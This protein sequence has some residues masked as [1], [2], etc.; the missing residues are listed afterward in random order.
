MKIGS[1]YI[2]GGVSGSA[3]KSLEQAYEA[4]KETGFKA[5]FDAA[6]TSGDDEQLKEAAREFEAYFLGIML[7]QMRRTVIDGG[8]IE[9]SEARKHFETMLDEEY[10][11]NMSSGEGIGIANAIYEAMKR[12]Y[13]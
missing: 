3:Q 10:A 1:D 11:R 12:A 6:V 7:K 2:A 9:K 8:L 4:S 13:E 5:L